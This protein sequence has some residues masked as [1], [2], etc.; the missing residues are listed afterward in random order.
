LPKVHTFPLLAL[1]L[2]RCSFTAAF[3]SLRLMF[4]TGSRHYERGSKPSSRI[5]YGRSGASTRPTNHT[6]S[7]TACSS[8][9]SHCPPDGSIRAASNWWLVSIDRQKCD[10]NVTFGTLK[11]PAGQAFRQK[12]NASLFREIWRTR[13]EGESVSQWR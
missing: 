6:T 9:P 2:S 7:S 4:V 3:A 5:T 12:R 1:S 11:F 13:Y 10:A 8:T